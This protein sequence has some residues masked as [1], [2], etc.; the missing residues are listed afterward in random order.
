M[1]KSAWLLNKMESFNLF[2]G[3][4]ISKMKIRILTI[5]ILPF[6]SYLLYFLF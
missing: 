3:N 5:A 1:L 4:S 6:I 2:F